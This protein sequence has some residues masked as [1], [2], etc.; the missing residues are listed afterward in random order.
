M[1]RPFQVKQ[2][3]SRCCDHICNRWIE[4]LIEAERARVSR[5]DQQSFW[6]FEIVNRLVRV[7]ANVLKIIHIS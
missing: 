1:A 5:N 4:M 3:C 6:I 2:D 7:I